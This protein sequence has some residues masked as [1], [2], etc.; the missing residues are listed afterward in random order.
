MF[1]NH[2]CEF[3]LLYLQKDFAY[4]VQSLSVDG[5]K[6]IKHNKIFGCALLGVKQ[7]QKQVYLN[8]ATQFIHLA[9]L[10]GS[11][12]VFQRQI[13]LCK[14]FLHNNNPWILFI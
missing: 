3:A 12:H 13:K 6:S 11:R 14:M 10:P 4:I 1:K 2:S 8:G 7:K 9:H 5:A